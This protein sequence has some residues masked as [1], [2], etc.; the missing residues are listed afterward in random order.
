VKQS[1]KDNLI[2][3]IKAADFRKDLHE[4]ITRHGGRL[5][6]GWKGK[7]AKLQVQFPQDHEHKAVTILEVSRD[8]RVKYDVKV[9]EEKL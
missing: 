8:G 7:S 6:L 4:V 2:L 3:A 9:E 5:V 1:E